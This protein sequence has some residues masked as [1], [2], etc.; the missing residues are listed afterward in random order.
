MTGGNIWQSALI[1]G[2]GGAV[3]G[4]V[5]GHI[6]AKSAEGIIGGAMAGGAAAG[7][8]SS[9]FSGGNFLENTLFG[10]VNSGLLAT[11]V[12]GARSIYRNVAGYDADLSPG[13]EP[14]KKDPPFRPVP[15]TDNV[16][17]ADPTEPLFWLVG[18]G[19]R[20]SRIL[21]SI[22][23]I[24]SLAGFHNNWMVGFNRLSFWILNFPTIPPS[25]VINYV[26][27]YQVRH[28]AIFWNHILRGGERNNMINVQTQER[29]S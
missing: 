25:L 19:S 12:V 27:L 24:N 1:G 13:G 28:Q 7:A 10:G 29:R 2:I 18:E 20:I 8:V 11:A 14:A 16:G 4:G 21:N 22:S 17:L 15:G 3:G 6:G 9:A 5:A 23:G 26:A